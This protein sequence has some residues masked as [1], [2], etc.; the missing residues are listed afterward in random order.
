MAPLSKGGEEIRR[1]VR[2]FDKFPPDVRKDLRIKLKG[3]GNKALF[4][5][6]LQASWSTRIPRA[7][8]LKIAINKKNPGLAIEVNR[9][10]APH[11]RPYE[12][13]NK[14]GT[15]RAPLFGDRSRWYSHPAR[16]FLVRGARPWFETTDK[17]IKEVVD[18]VAKQVG[19]KG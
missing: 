7:T 12:N 16:P 6:R 9:N 1:F 15:F 5:V 4:S 10:K 11:A 18:L 13:D 17:E 2:R 8:S 14:D 3:V 19:F